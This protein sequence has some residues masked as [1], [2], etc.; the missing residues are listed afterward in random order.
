MNT[1]TLSIQ[2]MLEES[3]YGL[4]LSLLSGGKGLANRVSSSRLQKPGLALAGYAEHLQ[5]ALDE[6]LPG[7]LGHV[8]TV[9]AKD[10]SGLG[11]AIA[12]VVAR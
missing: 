8:S 4:E 1:I 2:D 11:A 9:L 10:G 5:H 12:A 7:A 6:L 3:D